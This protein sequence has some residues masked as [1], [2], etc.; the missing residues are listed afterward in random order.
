MT[1]TLAQP[2]RSDQAPTG[3]RTVT[4][5]TPSGPLHLGALLAVIDPLRDLSRTH[6]S[7]VFVSDLHAL[8]LHHDPHELDRRRREVAALLIACGLDS[9]AVFLQSRV[10]EIAMLHFLLES[11][12]T[13]GEVARMVQ[14]REKSAQQTDRG[15]RMSLLSYPVLMA[16]D[17]LGYDVDVVPVGEDQLQHLELTRVL[18]RRF[19]SAY[20]ATFVV[21][22]PVVPHD[23]PR[24][25]DLADPARKM[26]KSNPVQRGVIRLL[27]GPDEVRRKVGRAV[28]GDGTTSAPGVTNLLGLLARLTGTSAEPTS[29]AAL[30]AQVTEA[31]VDRLA[32]IQRRYAELVRGPAGVDHRLGEGALQAR[33]LAGPVLARASAAIGLG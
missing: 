30:K 14:F 1:T 13:Y 28:T 29:Y 21:P 27:D 11:T 9:S 2:A 10:P 15:V 16:A 5:F 17:I 25:M 12:A 26:S 24:V 3:R 8:T 23:V 7:F 19:N 31:V 22:E 18:A 32:P 4:G 6:E 33:S 20:G